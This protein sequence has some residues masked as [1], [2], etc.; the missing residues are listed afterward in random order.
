MSSRCVASKD[1]LL[2]SF[3][4]AAF[5]TCRVDVFVCFLTPLRVKKKTKSNTESG[6][7]AEAADIKDV[8]RFRKLMHLL[9]STAD[10]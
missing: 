5:V 4:T 1:H 6:D 8:D 3:A 9:I 7:V 2:D 10:L